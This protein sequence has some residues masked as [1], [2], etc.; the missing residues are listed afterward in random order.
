[1]ENPEENSSCYVMLCR[2][3]KWCQLAE[4]H[5]KTE[6]IQ[7]MV[8]ALF[9]SL[10]LVV[11]CQ[12]TI[13]PY[14]I[15]AGEL[16]QYHQA[17]RLLQPRGAVDHVIDLN[18]N[19]RLM[20]VFIEALTRNTTYSEPR[21]LAAQLMPTWARSI[22]SSVHFQAL[23]LE[24][25]ISTDSNRCAVIADTR[26]DPV[27]PVVIKHTMHMLGKQRWQLHIFHTPD[28]AVFLRHALNITRTSKVI[29]LFSS[30]SKRLYIGFVCLSPFNQVRMHRLQSLSRD[31]YN[32][33]FAT[34]V[35]LDT[36]PGVCEHL[37][38]FQSD[39]VVRHR[40]EQSIEPYL[41]FDYVG[42][43]WKWANQTVS[44]TCSD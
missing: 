22:N 25:L 21:Q 13:P 35:L 32:A 3:K 2:P 44:Q 41:Q 40:L 10:L 8:V 20:D 31:S 36:L 34:N 19:V 30:Q 28:N 38:V 27:L 7:S 16:E 17:V 23:Q 24:E 37:L 42:A 39:V 4:M 9:I 14:A 18:H 12:A 43:P 15:P 26:S 11:Y 1:M 6:R 33:L 5:I 29:G